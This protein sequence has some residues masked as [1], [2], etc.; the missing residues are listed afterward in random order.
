[1]THP[2]SD[3][4]IRTV[5]LQSVVLFIGAEED[6]VKLQDQQLET[7]RYSPKVSLN[8]RVQRYST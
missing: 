8:T 1:M 2:Q 6:Y 7:Q 5:R 4:H 3:V